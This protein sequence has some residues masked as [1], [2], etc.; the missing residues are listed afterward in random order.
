[1]S[2]RS[3]LNGIADLPPACHAPAART[4]IPRQVRDARV[5]AMN[6]HLLAGTALVAALALPTAA[7]AD[8]SLIGGPVKVRDYQMTVIGSDGAQ[9]SLTV[10][11]SRTSG[12]D[13]QQH[14]WSFSSGVTVTPTSIKGSLGRFGSVK[15]TLAGARAAKGTVPKGCTGTTGTTRSGTL[16]GS[17]K[18]VADTTYFH[19]IT[20]KQ[21]EGTTSSGGTLR[22]DTASAPGT[23]GAPSSEPTLSVS[24]TD[25]GAMFSFTATPTLQSVLQ[26]DDPAATAPAQVMHTISASGT[27][28]KVSGGSATVPGLAPFIDGSGAFAASGEGSGGFAGGVLSGSLSARFDSIGP[29][30]VAGDAMLMNGR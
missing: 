17:F 10:M 3:A 30:A 2:L 19:A 7:S 4:A 20:A 27:G 15:L 25:G 23:S 13:S 18:L 1:V 24:R 16:R 14:V 28:L 26:M 6:R 12:G 11:L 8:T 9:D 29:V 22:C 21:L 5:G